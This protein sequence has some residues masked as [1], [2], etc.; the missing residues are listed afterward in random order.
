MNIDLWDVTP[1]S[2]VSISE[3]RAASIFRSEDGDSKF[4][5]YIGKYLSH[6][7]R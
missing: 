4:L 6:Y 2:V 5:R 7:T 3:E 1:C